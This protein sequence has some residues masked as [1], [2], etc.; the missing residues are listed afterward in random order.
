MSRRLRICH[1]N[2][3]NLGMMQRNCEWTGFDVFPNGINENGF[4]VGEA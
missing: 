2:L 4:T 3:G 1:C